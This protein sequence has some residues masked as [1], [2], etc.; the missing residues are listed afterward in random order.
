MQALYDR[1]VAYAV[2]HGFQGTESEQFEALC[3]FFHERIRANVDPELLE[4]LEALFP[5]SE[6]TAYGYH[7]WHLLD[8]KGAP[9]GKKLITMSGYDAVHSPNINRVMSAKAIFNFRLGHLKDALAGEMFHL[10]LFPIQAGMDTYLQKYAPEVEGLYQ[11]YLDGTS[12]EVL[13]PDLKRIIEELEIHNRNR[14]AYFFNI[15]FA[16]LVDQ[17]EGQ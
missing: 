11:R 13:A 10:E 15:A 7:E 16:D 5:C 2:K 4:L 6:H 1:L 14:L 12:L 8:D 3:L 17:L 9:D